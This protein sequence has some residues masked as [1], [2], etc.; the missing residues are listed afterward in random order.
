MRLIACFIV[1]WALSAFGGKKYWVRSV[2]FPGLSGLIDQRGGAAF[3]I[4]S[5]SLHICNLWGEIAWSSV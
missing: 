5:D 4:V 1:V 2:H 3:S